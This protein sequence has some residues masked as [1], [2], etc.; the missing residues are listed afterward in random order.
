ML[1]PFALYVSTI[2]DTFWRENNEFYH[3]YDL[4]EI[5]VKFVIYKKCQNC[6]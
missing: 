1:L 2:Q 3:K 5:Y 6:G 4:A